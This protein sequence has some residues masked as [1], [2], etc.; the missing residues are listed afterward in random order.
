MNDRRLVTAPAL[1]LNG[2]SSGNE[3]KAHST[4][5]VSIHGLL[6]CPDVA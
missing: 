2:K 5:L 3:L 1:A 4:S 6:T